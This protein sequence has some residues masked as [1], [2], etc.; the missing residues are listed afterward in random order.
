MRGTSSDV[1]HTEQSQ[2][3][4][5]SFVVNLNRSTGYAHCHA[6]K[7]SAHGGSMATHVSNGSFDVA[8]GLTGD[9]RS[10]LCAYAV[11]LARDSP[12]NAWTF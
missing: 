3:P 8:I 10:W 7:T 6:C 12:E 11:Y 4:K 2:Y 9:L 1:F 5:T